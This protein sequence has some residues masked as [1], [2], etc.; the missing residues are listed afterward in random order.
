M[1]YFNLTQQN[2]DKQDEFDDL[3]NKLKPSLIVKTQAHLYRNRLAKNKTL[4]KVFK[5]ESQTNKCFG[6]KPKNSDTVSNNQE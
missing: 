6:Y 1:L 2:K 4:L 5:Q 3:F